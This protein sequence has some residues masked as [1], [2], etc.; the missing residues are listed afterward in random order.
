MM[1]FDEV[2]RSNLIKDSDGCPVLR[3]KLENSDASCYYQCG[4]HRIIITFDDIIRVLNKEAGVEPLSCDDVAPIDSIYHF[5]SVDDE[6]AYVNIVNRGEAISSCSLDCDFYDLLSNVI[7][8]SNDCYAI[9]IA[10]A[11][12]VTDEPFIDCS[13]S[14]IDSLAILN[15][16][17]RET[18]SGYGI[19]VHFESSP[20]NLCNLF[21]HFDRDVVAL[22]Y[23]LTLFVNSIFPAINLL[24]IASAETALLN[25]IQSSYQAE[26]VSMTIN[27]DNSILI[28]VY[29]TNMPVGN[30]RIEAV[31]FSDIVTEGILTDCD[32]SIE[33]RE[34]GGFELIEDGGFE[35]IE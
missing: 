8:K 7:V 2:F 28:A 26:S 22:S 6:Y 18:D 23:D 16:L 35:L 33:L 1:Q 29:Q 11:S 25:H 24:N 19:A 12:D 20:T 30:A 9:C 5:L 34:D 10:E 13:N 15:L 27:D 3:V 14:D 4:G 32:G 21:V 31:L 17:I